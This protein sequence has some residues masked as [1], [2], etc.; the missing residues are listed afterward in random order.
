MVLST[1]PMVYDDDIH[2]DDYSD[3]IAEVITMLTQ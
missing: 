2:Y 3:W 1:I